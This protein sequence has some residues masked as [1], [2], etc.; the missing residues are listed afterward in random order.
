M[1][2]S[3]SFKSSQGNSSYNSKSSQAKQVAWQGIE[4]SLP[5]KTAATTFALSSVFILL[6][7]MITFR[8]LYT[9]QCVCLFVYKYL[10]LYSCAEGCTQGPFRDTTALRE[11]VMRLSSLVSTNRPLKQSNNCMVF[12]GL[13]SGLFKYQNRIWHHGSQFTSKIQDINQF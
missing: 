4:K 13:G 11:G 5:T 8:E 3:F 6:L 1:N 2:S 7:Y 9:V 10:G 12:S